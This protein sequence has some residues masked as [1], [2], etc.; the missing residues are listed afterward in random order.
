MVDCFSFSLLLGSNPSPPLICSRH[1]RHNQKPFN[2]TVVK[3]RIQPLYQMATSIAHDS[4]LQKANTL[5]S[6]CL[7]MWRAWRHQGVTHVP[8]VPR[9][10]RGSLKLCQ[11]CGFNSCVR[12]FFI[13]WGSREFYDHIWGIVTSNKSHGWNAR[14]WLVER[15]NAALWLA[16]P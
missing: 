1:F 6:F 3:A 13:P 4:F 2:Q 12:V 11:E 15:K 5:Y 10:S 8:L 9:V 14:F 16:E 7:L